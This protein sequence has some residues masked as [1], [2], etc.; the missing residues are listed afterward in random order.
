MKHYKIKSKNANEIEHIQEKYQELIKTIAITIFLDKRVNENE[1]YQTKEIISLFFPKKNKFFHNI[2]Y[3]LVIS[4]LEIYQ[5][6][7]SIFSDDKDNIFDFITKNYKLHKLIEKIIRS[8]KHISSEE[9]EFL[10]LYKE[11]YNEYLLKNELQNDNSINTFDIS[12][13]IV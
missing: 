11:K 12:N 13:K 3:T 10:K 1:L 9:K 2:F 6:Y 8:D 5:L 4:K 7:P